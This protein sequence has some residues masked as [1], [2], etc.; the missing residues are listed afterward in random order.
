MLGSPSGATVHTEVIKRRAPGTIIA[1]A[2]VKFIGVHLRDGRRLKS[3]AEIQEAWYKE[4][5]PEQVIAENSDEAYDADELVRASHTTC[6][7]LLLTSLAWQKDILENDDKL[8]YLEELY[9]S[10]PQRMSSGQLGQCDG[11][12]LFNYVHKTAQRSLQQ[13]RNTIWVSDD[14]RIISRNENDKNR[15]L[16]T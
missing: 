9:Y 3:L 1:L 6:Y 4:G 14:P 13:F 7:F 5:M 10:L 12:G 8:S 11:T 16:T 2:L 15:C